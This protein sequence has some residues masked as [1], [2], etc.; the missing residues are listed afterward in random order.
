MV[1]LEQLA[2]A[3]VAE[4]ARPLGRADDV[5]E[6]HRGEHAV[7]LGAGRDAGQEL[8]DL[9]ERSRPVADPR[10]V[11]VARQLDE[12]APGICSAM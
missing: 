6:Q 8:L 3:P 1:A 12:R 10:Q 2:P 7:G 4:L 11:V 9:V 5:G